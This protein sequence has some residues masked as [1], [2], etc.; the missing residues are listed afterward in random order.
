[1][2]LFANNASRVKKINTEL[3]KNTLRS[4]DYA[5]KAQVASATGLSVAT[6]GTILNELLEQG[7]VL[8]AEL[9]ESSGGRPARRYRYN[10]DYAYIAVLLVRTEGGRHSIQASV[11]NL[12]G[13]LIHDELRVLEHIDAEVIDARI[14]ELLAAYEQIRAVGIGIPGVAHHGVIGVC[15]VPALAHRAL[16]P[17]L[18]DKHGI[19][20]LIEN[21]MN[22]TVYGLYHRQQYDEEAVFAAITLVEDHFPGAGFM[23]NGRLV[24][25]HTT[26]AGEIS[27]LPH[28]MSRAEQL[29]RINQPD[30][31]LPLVVSIIL[32]IVSILNPATIALTG[33]MSAALS[34]EEVTE[35]CLKHL[36]KEH[37]PELFVNTETSE[38]YRF[39]L[40]QATLE[41]LTY[42]LQLIERKI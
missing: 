12:A 40:L 23:V 7:E 32:S 36:P 27:F 26:F 3:I 11:A 14:E 31:M 38:E 8:E 37:M 18:Q 29:R 19:E 28:V 42:H 2:S 20:V 1:M 24:R 17:E 5:T 22:M 4:L 35:G 6:C 34:L 30:E 16:G 21:D 10:P 13:E 39:G 15:D 33:T 9:E 25:G 41:R